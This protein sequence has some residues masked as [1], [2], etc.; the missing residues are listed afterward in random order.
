MSI[1]QTHRERLLDGLARTKSAAIVATA[2]H[3]VRNNDCEYRFRPDSDFWYLT[4]FAEPGALLVLLP[5]GALGDEEPRRSI[6]FLREKNAKLETWTGRRL[7][8]QAA[9]KT[10][11]VDA[12]Y[13]IEDIWD[14][15]G[16][17][18][19]NYQSIV[20]RTGLSEER[21]RKVLAMIAGLRNKARGGI[22]PPVELID[23]APS[24]HEQRLFKSPA[25]LE[26]MRAAA[27][28]TCEAHIAA[29]ER[30]APGVG[31]NEIDA[32]IEYTFR[33][34]G[35]TGMAYTTIAAGGDNACILHYVENDEPLV[36]GELLLVDAG[37]EVE[38]YASDVTRTYP[39]NGSFNPAQKEIYELVLEAQLAAIEA[40]QPGLAMDQVHAVA[41][42]VLTRG[43]IR[44]GLLAGEGDKTAEE[45]AEERFTIHKTSHWLGLDV[46]DCG[47]YCAADEPRKLEP[48]MVLTVEPGLYISAD[49][50]S[51]DERWRGIGVRIE[52]DILVTAEGSENLTAQIPKTIEAVE[53]ACAGKVLATLA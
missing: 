28:I 53:A 52:D 8:V 33:C 45:G 27:A 30:A 19:K 15:L 29:M 1:Y 9:P 23:P 14:V 38:Y 41:K 36:D 51:V 47:S 4:G 39:V 6:L 11:G 16:D 12:A 34:R 22:Q 26:L 25:E 46:H 49:D 24:L 21:D 32:L 13:D 18:L 20:Y 7:G 40:I 37:C 43:L 42:R 31:E 10:L 3:K 35:A 50:E 5:D 44:L 2:T 17:L 48:G